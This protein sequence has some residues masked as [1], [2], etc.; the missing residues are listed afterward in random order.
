MRLSM[1]HN[2]PRVCPKD[3][4]LYNENFKELS[5]TRAL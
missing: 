2:S 1:L 3:E 5:Q 4:I